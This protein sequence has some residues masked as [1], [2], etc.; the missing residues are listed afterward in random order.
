MRGWRLRQRS[1]RHRGLGGEQGSALGLRGGEG[2][3]A[4]AAARHLTALGDEDQDAAAK[5]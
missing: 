1:K 5:T 2:R 4:G 3:G